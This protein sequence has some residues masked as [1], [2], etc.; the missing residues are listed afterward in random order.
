MYFSFAAGLVPASP[1]KPAAV[2]KQPPA[3]A[4]QPAAPPPAYP[5]VGAPGAAA[6]ATPAKTLSGI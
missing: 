2:T 4:S 3:P 1:V 5:T 6:A